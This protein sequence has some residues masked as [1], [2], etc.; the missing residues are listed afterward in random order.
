MGITLALH[1]FLG[2]KVPPLNQRQ[3]VEVFHLP[4]RVE[5]EFLSV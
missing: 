2:K 3:I 5:L 4:F 1:D